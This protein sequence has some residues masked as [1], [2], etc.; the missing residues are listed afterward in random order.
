MLQLDEAQFGIAT[1]QAAAFYEYTNPNHLL[2][3]GWISHAPLIADK[4][5][6]RKVK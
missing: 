2:G 4:K 1:G 5:I 6:N 3:G